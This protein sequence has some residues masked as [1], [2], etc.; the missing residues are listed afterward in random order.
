MSAPRANKRPKQLTLHGDTRVDEFFWLRERENAEVLAYL[1]R[2]NRYTELQMAHT[3][4]LQDELYN[5]IRGRIQ[6]DDS[7]APYQDGD[8]WYYSRMVDGKQYPL[9]CRKKGLS[10][11]EEVILDVNELALSGVEG[12]S[13]LSVA[14]VRVS[15]IT[16]CWFLAKMMLVG[17]STPF[18]SKTFVPVTSSRTRLLMR[19]P[20]WFGQMTQNGVLFEAGPEHAADLPDASARTRHRPLV[21]RRGV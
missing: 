3:R 20:T 4:E 2:E 17:E 5:E 21:R 6:Q 10:A 12:Q 14:G 1:E 15:P 18:T 16:S 11:Q 7:T 13:Y 9:Y 19:R 8:Y